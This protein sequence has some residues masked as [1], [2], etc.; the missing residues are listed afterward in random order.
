MRKKS[1]RPYIILGLF[2]LGLFYLPKGFVEGLRSMVVG[3][4]KGPSSAGA[5]FLSNQKKEDVED[6]KTA[7]LLLKKQNDF[8][9]RRLLSE[10]RIE[11]QIE[12]I[13]T[14]VDINE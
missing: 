5:V 1:Y 7:L 6:L 4:T 3:M 9:R 8:L 10:E 14:L 2:L 11:R 12:R 13:R